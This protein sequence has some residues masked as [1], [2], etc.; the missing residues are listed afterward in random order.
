VCRLLASVCETLLTAG[1]C[2]GLFYRYVRGQCQHIHPSMCEVCRSVP[3]NVGLFYLC[4]GILVS[5]TDMCVG[6][7]SAYAREY[8]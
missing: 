6:K 8:L 1:M 3:W 2:S 5:F 4:E 7:V